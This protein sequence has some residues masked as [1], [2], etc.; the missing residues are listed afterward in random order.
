VR[1][2]LATLVAA[3]S[4][5]PLRGEAAEACHGDVGETLLALAPTESAAGG[6]RI[7]TRRGAGASWVGVEVLGERQTSSRPLVVLAWTPGAGRAPGASRGAPAQLQGGARRVRA[8]SL[9]GAVAAAAAGIALL[10]DAASTPGA[11]GRDLAVVLVCGE[12]PAAAAAVAELLGPRAASALVVLPGGWGRRRPGKR[13]VVLVDGL[14]PLGVRFPARAFGSA[15]TRANLEGLAHPVT[16]GP[17]ERPYLATLASLGVGWKATVLRRM[18]RGSG[19]VLAGAQAAALAAH[20]AFGPL[21][22]TRC[23]AAKPSADGAAGAPGL[24]CWLSSGDTPEALCARLGRASGV[25][26]E[27]LRQA[28]RIDPALP[29]PLS[30]ICRDRCLPEGNAG[31]SD[32]PLLV[33]RPCATPDQCPAL[34]LRTLGVR[35]YGVPPLPCVLKE[36]NGGAAHQADAACLGAALRLLH[37]LAS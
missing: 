5:E 32:A 31:G 18:V 29:L 7:R 35:A 14:R 26:A 16:L 13:P 11:A 4:L 30:P 36:L 8:P 37:V 1:A 19:G 21:A 17:A 25:R 20:P 28:A 24:Q 27:A 2:L 15:S 3:S 23:S 33:A 6:D 12:A 34:A 9:S 22:R 10:R